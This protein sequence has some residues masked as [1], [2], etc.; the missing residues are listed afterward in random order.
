MKVLKFGGTSVGNAENINKV[1]EIVRSEIEKNSCAVVLSAMSGAT[2]ALINIVKTAESGDVSFRLKI[3]ELET[4]H[5]ETAKNLLGE[6]SRD[7]GGI[8]DF[9]ENRFN[10]LKNICEGVFL[11]R[12]LSARTLDHVVSFGERI[13]T[14]LVAAKF[15]SLGIENV[16]KDSRQLIKT[17]SNFGSAAT[18]NEGFP[19]ESCLNGAVEDFY[20]EMEAQESYFRELLENAKSKNLILKYVASFAGGKASVGLPSIN[21][22][23]NFANLSGKDDAV[24]F[25][26]IVTP[27][28][29]LVI[30]GAG[31]GA[32]DVTT[33][34]VF[35]DIIRAARI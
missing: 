12:E 3:K 10:E 5:T 30:K 29:P 19:P 33:A 9:I 14:K 31:A 4:K 34:G 27:N 23:H 22:N 18:E 35:A 2:D 13:S 6:N 16:W 7:G 1:I 32:E 17:D 20:S 11:L 15:N 24:F 28:L 25:T 8:F 26:R 21:K